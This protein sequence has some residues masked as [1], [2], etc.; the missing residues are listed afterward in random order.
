MITAR[1]LFEN[2]R[3]LAGELGTCNEADFLSRLSMAGEMLMKR[4]DADG[5]LWTWCLGCPCGNCIVLPSM[6]RAVRQVWIGDNAL[7][8]RSQWW[9]GRLA[10]NVDV[11]KHMEVPWANFIDS[12]R[13]IATSVIANMKITEVFEIHHSDPTDVGADI[14]VHYISPNHSIK[15]WKG[16]TK[17]NLKPIYGKA[18]MGEVVQFVKP[19]TN[20]NVELW[21]RDLDTG[22][23]R[24]LSVYGAAQETPQF[25][26]YE[27][28]GKVTGPINIKGKRSWTPIRSLDDLVWFGDSE[29]WA[30][31][32]QAQAAMM[33]GDPE[34]KERHLAHAITCLAMDLRDKSGPAQAQGVQFVTPWTIRNQG[35]HPNGFRRV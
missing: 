25:L 34:T 9:N 17:G 21:A 27:I 33:N 14:E 16:T 19:R 11:Q 3:S 32:L 22:K 1:Q 6:I 2:V 20:G 23:R 29:V 10:R 24:L 5:M 30:S 26:V 28:T 7:D 12:G 35:G 15:V 18:G 13:R 31:A 4:I 8:I